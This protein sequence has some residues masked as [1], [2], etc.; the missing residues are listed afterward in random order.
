MDEEHD[1][2]VHGAA[3]P[4]DVEDLPRMGAVT[5]APSHFD[6]GFRRRSE[7]RPIDLEHHVAVALDLGAPDGADLGELAA[8]RLRQVGERRHAHSSRTQS[9][10]GFQNGVSR[11]DCQVGRSKIDMPMNAAFA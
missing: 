7:Q 8:G 2:Y 11:S 5:D 9:T 6:T 3:A 10:I 4:V 1:R